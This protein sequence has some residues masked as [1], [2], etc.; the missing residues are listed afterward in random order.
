MNHKKLEL[1]QGQGFNCSQQ[2]VAYFLGN[3]E[4]SK[5]IGFGGGIGGLRQTCGAITGGVMVLGKWY[6]DAGMEK[7]LIY[8]EIQSFY[9][10]MEGKIG[11]ANCQEI[12]GVPHPDAPATDY[13]KMT[14]CQK[15]IELVIEYIEEVL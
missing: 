14:K 11:S 2:V 12:L 4:A 6:Y 10:A 5:A 13:M 15:A 9:R 3:E 1:L 7:A 8:E